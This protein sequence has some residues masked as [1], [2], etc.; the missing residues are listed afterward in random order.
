MRRWLPVLLYLVL[1]FGLSSVRR[2]PPVA[3]GPQIDKVWHLLEY[4]GL[5]LL[6]MRAARPGWGSVGERAALVL[7]FGAL[8]GG[9][10]ELYQSTVPGRTPA[11]SDAV[12]DMIGTGLGILVQTRH[13][14]RR[15]TS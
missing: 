12:A 3:P 15:G 11:V 5:G 8:V 4:A 6:A 1:I 7:A 2:P 10:D 9:I 13:E 14:R